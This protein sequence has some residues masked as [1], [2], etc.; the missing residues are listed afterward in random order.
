MGR[1]VNIRRLIWLKQETFMTT[2]S[3][4][5]LQASTRG[6]TSRALWLSPVLAALLLG[7]CANMTP[8]QQKTAQGAAIGAVAGAVISKA[9][10]NKA[11]TGAVLGGVA[12]AV[13]GNVWSR[14]MEEQQR[15]MEAATQGTP[16]EVTRT[17]DNQLKL[18]IPSDISFD[19]N[20]AAIKPELRSVLDA[21]AK[22]VS[23]NSGMIV[24]IVGHTD[25]TGTD[26]INEPLSQRRA[27]S[28]RDYLS[29]RGVSA[30]RIETA[31]R[32]SREPI[33]SNATA[34]GQAKNR[35]VEIFLREP[36]AG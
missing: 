34:E 20:S 17:A 11:A 12:G 22:G 27:E 18:E 6:N 28:V 7:G 8:E 9:T 2:R 31:G 1:Y 36:S 3:I 4:A 24:R 26:A 19:R 32:G 21:F 15:A 33:A 16:V 25:S 13:A 14:R 29:D 5:P 23:Q 10:G 30:N 35:R